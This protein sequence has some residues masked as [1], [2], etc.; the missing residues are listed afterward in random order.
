MAF[1]DTVYPTESRNS[2]GAP[3]TKRGPVVTSQ[4]H[5]QTLD[6]F[7]G[8]QAGCILAR[9]WKCFKKK[10]ASAWR[11]LSLVSLFSFVNGKQMLIT[12]FVVTCWRGLFGMHTKLLF[13]SAKQKAFHWDT[14]RWKGNSLFKRTKRKKKQKTLYSIALHALFIICLNTE[15]STTELNI[16]SFRCRRIGLMRHECTRRIVYLEHLSSVCV[17]YNTGLTGSQ[18][19]FKL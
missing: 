6:F 5:R 15:R 8:C 19:L 7:R 9:T 3:C 18:L 10:I 11:L 16:Y 4:N 1:G 2:Q 17:Y 14:I 13:A 12:C